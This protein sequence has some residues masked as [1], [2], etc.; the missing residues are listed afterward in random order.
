MPRNKPDT[1]ENEITPTKNADINILAKKNQ[2]LVDQVESISI[3]N[4]TND[5]QELNDTVRSLSDKI[6]NLAIKSE[7]N[8]KS[9]TDNIA[10]IRDNLIQGLIKFNKDTSKRITTME[11]RILFLEKDLNVSSQRMHGN[12]IEFTGVPDSIQD[13]FLEANCIE[14]V[15]KIGINVLKNEIQGIHR[16]P[17]RRGSPAKPVIA[18]FVK[19]KLPESIMRNKKKFNK[20]NFMQLGFLSDTKIYVNLSSS[21][22]ILRLSLP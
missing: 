17:Y 20:V 16:L 11:L 10:H 6:G 8:H 21:F 19:R 12:T 3:S 2:K 18:K 14:M 1:L 7:A 4:S 22:Q 15:E 5:I 9:V 13:E